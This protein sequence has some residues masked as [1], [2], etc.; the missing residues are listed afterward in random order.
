MSTFS[1]SFADP[2][3][4]YADFYEPLRSTIEAAGE[5]W[6]RYLPGAG[7]IEI[8]VRFDPAVSTAASASATAVPDGTSSGLAVYKEGVGAE[9]TSG[10]DSNGAAPDAELTIGPS[11]LDR[12]SFDPDPTSRGA[13]IDSGKADALSVVTHELG[14]MIA[15]DGWKDPVTGGLPGSY[16]SAFDAQTTTLPGGTAF[17]G[18]G[19]TAVYGGPVPLSDGAPGHLGHEGD[20]VASDLMN[21]IAMEAQTRY[22]ISALDVAMMQDAGMKVRAASPGDDQ[23]WGFPSG[24]RISGNAG[25][26]TIHG[27]AGNDTLVGGDGRDWIY[28]GTGND[29]V[30]SGRGDDVLWG[31]AGRDVFEYQALANGTAPDGSDTIED[32]A[33]GQDALRLVST[34]PQGVQVS[35]HQ[36]GTHV[37]LPGGTIILAGTH[38]Y[39]TVAEAGA[40]LQFA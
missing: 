21:G 8:E 11:Y 24:D 6:S 16:Q 9:M 27:L 12:L 14:H 28:G 40:W 18:P 1:V 17:V 2:S 29:R 32:F 23:L 37:D 30:L 10:I 34:R 7:S 5:L 25:N 26:D 15:L 31:G 3:N 35:D 19:A 33:L 22:E 38:G 20:D 4:A 39:D 13:P 36:D